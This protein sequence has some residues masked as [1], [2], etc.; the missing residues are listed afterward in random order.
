MFSDRCDHR[1]LALTVAVELPEHS[2]SQNIRMMARLHGWFQFY[3]GVKTINC[4]LQRVF[5]RLIFD[6][7]RGW[8]VQTW[9]R[10]YQLSLNDNTHYVT[11]RAEIMRW[12][13]HGLVLHLGA[14]NDECS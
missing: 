2:H 4:Y 8:S 7:R 13:R 11:G 9:L 3:P 1:L 14:D 10:S 12:I 5:P 6:L